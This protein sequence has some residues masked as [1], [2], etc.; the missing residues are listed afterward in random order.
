MPQECTV[1]TPPVQ[2]RPMPVRPTQRP[3]VGARMPTKLKEAAQARMVQVAPGRWIPFHQETPPEL[4]LCEWKPNQD[5]TFHPWPHEERLVRISAKLARLLGFEGN[6]NTLYRLGRMGCIEII[7][8]APRFYLLNLTSWFNHLR[9][10]SED[11]EFWSEQK[12][13]ISEYRKVIF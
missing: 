8:A 1:K 2:G 5:G 3:T 11:P 13:N 12:G 6:W 4:S 7:Q 10:C 9:R